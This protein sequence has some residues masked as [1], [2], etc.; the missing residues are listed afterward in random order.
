[1]TQN[2]DAP[3]QGVVEVRW[4][5]PTAGQNLHI[6]QAG[7]LYAV[8]RDSISVAA[9]GESTSVDVYQQSVPNSC[10][11]P[12]QNACIWTAQSDVSWITITTSMPQSGDN[13]VRFTVA[14]NPGTA[15]RTGTITVRDKTV[16]VTQAGS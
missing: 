2:Y 5:T 6:E 14:P 3:R 1:V 16:R 11:G 4:P 12:L 7:C 13:P 10:G 15:A 9:A 8:T